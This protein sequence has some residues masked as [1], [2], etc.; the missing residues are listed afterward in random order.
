MPRRLFLSMRKATDGLRGREIEDTEDCPADKSEPFYQA[1]L[2]YVRDPERG[3]DVDDDGK[4]IG[5][6]EHQ[7]DGWDDG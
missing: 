3:A 6:K 5:Y 4:T 7:A 2:A 1:C